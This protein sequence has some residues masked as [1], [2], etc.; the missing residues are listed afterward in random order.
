MNGDRRKLHH[1]LYII[2]NL[3]FHILISLFCFYN[4]IIT[5]KRNKYMPNVNEK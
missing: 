1:S 5:Q 3:F 2:F 4:V